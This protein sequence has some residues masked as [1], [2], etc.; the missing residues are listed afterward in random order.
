MLIAATIVLVIWCWHM[1][2]YQGYLRFFA[3][4]KLLYVESSM[5]YQLF[6]L[7]KKALNNFEVSNICEQGLYSMF[8]RIKKVVCLS[9]STIM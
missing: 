4:L 8:I 5:S 2:L 6:L 9:T 7:F 3:K 1:P